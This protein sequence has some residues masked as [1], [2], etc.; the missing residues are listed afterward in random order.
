VIHVRLGEDGRRAWSTCEG[1]SARGYAFRGGE[2]LGGAE[3]AA[4]VRRGSLL[5]EQDQRSDPSPSWMPI[6]RPSVPHPRSS[7]DGAPNRQTPLLTEQWHTSE[8]PQH[9]ALSGSTRESCSQILR[10]LNGSFAVV[11]HDDHR[12]EAAVDQVR[13]TPLFYGVRAGD[14][15]LSD[16][17]SWVRRQVRDDAIDDVAAA[18]F[19]MTGYVTGADTLYPNVKQ[20]QAGE[21]LAVENRENG[22]VVRTSRYAEFVHVA[23]VGNRCHTPTGHALRQEFDAVLLGA[24]ERLVRS[25]DGRPV[26]L[27][28]S[29]GF[30]SRLIALMLKRLGHADVTCFTYGLEG[31]R[32]SNVSRELAG[33]LGFRWEFVPYTRERWYDWFHSE[34]RERYYA[35]AD[36]LCSIPHLQDWPAV[37]ELKRRGLVAD[38]AVFVPGHTG[39]FISGGHIP[40]A[41]G[42]ARRFDVDRLVR[43]IEEK[44]YVLN[45]AE[46]VGDALAHE[47]R[48][49]L[50]GRFSGMEIATA[51]QAASAYEWWE[52][53]ERQAKFICNSARVYEFWGYDWRMPLWDADVMAFWERVPLS[54]RMGK[55]LYN[56][57]VRRLG[58]DLRVAPPNEETRMVGLVRSCLSALRLTKLR[59]RLQHTMNA[60]SARRIY[61]EHFLGWFGVMPENVFRQ[62]YTGREHLNSFLT[63][64]RLGRLAL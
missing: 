64:E 21:H 49:K 14:F 42:R 2:F 10:A 12:L 3:L 33:R 31:N 30:D 52:W 37:G 43:L 18:E 28:L 38:N 34:E 53:Q 23:P 58:G 11:R 56:D 44:H 29:G 63:R 55:C 45:G 25:L 7:E 26:V 15:F 59:A 24:F 13:S 6:G 60:R 9:T 16:E 32:E 41:I 17:A 54:F 22:P 47:V 57:Y 62:H 20:L 1:A 27:P 40:A 51:E 8:E 5:T 46:A 61:A 50:R 35:F 39:D 36:G 4:T 48:R 19:Q